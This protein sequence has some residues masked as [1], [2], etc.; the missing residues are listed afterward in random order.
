MSKNSILIVIAFLSSIVYGYSQNPW[1]N[2][3]DFGLVQANGYG[4]IEYNERYF[5]MGQGLLESDPN[6]E[7]NTFYMS[8]DLEGDYINDALLDDGPENTAPSFNNIC[9]DIIEIDG[10]LYSLADD[11]GATYMHK[12]DCD[13][14]SL[15]VLYDYSDP[16]H[17]LGGFTPVSCS[18]FPKGYF[19]GV[20]ETGYLP[21][22]DAQER[23]GRIFVTR[24]DPSNNDALETFYF[25]IDGEDIRPRESIIDNDGNMIILGYL[26]DYGV[27]AMKIDQDMELVASQIY[28]GQWK[29]SYMVAAIDENDDIMIG[30]THIERIGLEFYTKPLLMKLD[31]DLDTLWVK[32]FVQDSLVRDVNT[33]YITG[34]EKSSEGNGFI[35]CGSENSDT[36][37]RAGILSKIDYDGDTL[38][39]KKIRS[40]Q[41][42]PRDSELFSVIATSDRNYMAVG[43]NFTKTYHDSIGSWSQT[44]LVK[45]DGDGHIV[46][47][48]VSVTE[49]GFTDE[50]RLYPNPSSD[51]MYIEHDE[52]SGVRYQL[53]DAVG[54]MVYATDDIRAQS[55]NMLDVSIYD[56]G[57]YYLHISVSGTDDYHVEKLVIE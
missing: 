27:F 3:Y 12:T 10:S 8:V 52:I 4:L 19:T 30:L 1:N 31:R 41:N 43:K 14:D 11:I 22:P 24:V 53:Y 34:I 38:W 29:G 42:V 5:V 23:I 46:E 13:L 16:M 37:A 50:I 45:F 47:D 51:Y 20:T 7:R 56:S 36:Q 32:P 54:R 49:P 35:I 39:Y 26:D 28:R 9:R 48:G 15:L 44:W 55:I 21:T 18:E 57:I 17:N 40:L 33:N 2:T 6:L 25:Q